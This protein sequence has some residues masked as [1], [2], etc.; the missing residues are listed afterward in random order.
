[1]TNKAALIVGAP[2]R[3]R[4][5]VQALL[6]AN[7]VTAAVELADSGL[8]AVKAVRNCCPALV[9]VI[10]PRLEDGIPAHLRRIKARCA[11]SRLLLLGGDAHLESTATAAGA[12]RFALIGTPAPRLAEII[13][14]LLSDSGEHS[15]SEL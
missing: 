13:T 10:M 1:M 3:L 4:D 11:S 9:V 12:D 8:A 14:S 7:H 15:R 6:Q 2:S 5:G